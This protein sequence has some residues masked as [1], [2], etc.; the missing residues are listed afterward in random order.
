M[1]FCGGYLS[2]FGGFPSNGCSLL[3]Q[4]FSLNFSAVRKYKARHTPRQYARAAD[5]TGLY[6]RNERSNA[7]ILGELKRSGKT[8][9]VRA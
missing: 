3:C 8:F 7:G 6:K 1:A 5:I 4:P 2:A 9:V